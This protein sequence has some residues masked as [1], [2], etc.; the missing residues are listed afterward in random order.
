LV[1]AY[2]EQLMQEKEPQTVKQSLAAIRMLFN[3]LVIGQ[4]V[5]S[6]QPRRCAVP[7]YSIKKAKRRCSRRR[8]RACY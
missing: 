8:M 5:P 7:K 2:I 6:I 3:W 1:A 4:V